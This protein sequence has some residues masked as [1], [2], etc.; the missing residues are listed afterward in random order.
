MTKLFASQW[1]IADMNLDDPNSR[2]CQVIELAKL[3]SV[4]S[5]HYKSNLLPHV[6]DNSKTLKQKRQERC[7][8]G[9]VGLLSCRDHIDIDDDPDVYLV[10]CSNKDHVAD[11][12]G[13]SASETSKLM[14]KDETVQDL[15]AFF[16]DSD[17][18]MISTLALVGGPVARCNMLARSLTEW[19]H[20]PTINFSPHPDH[21]S[22]KTIRSS[23]LQFWV[24]FR[25][26]CRKQSDDNR[27]PECRKKKLHRA[28]IIQWLLSEDLFLIV[29]LLQ[30]NSDI[31][32]YYASSDKDVQ[33][34]LYALWTDGQTHFCNSHENVN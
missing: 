34:Q 23:A 12:D 14:F 4:G 27:R 1:S 15:V 5:I 33:R 25:Y 20:Q 11:V 13:K 16:S 32:I 24:D 26:C 2:R 31:G 10:R 30:S 9:T 29:S 17:T 3:M 8:L 21:G 7:H 6:E 18:S 28:V 22:I 19:S